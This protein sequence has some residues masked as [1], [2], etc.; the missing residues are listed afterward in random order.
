MMSELFDEILAECNGINGEER[1]E[2][3]CL[4]AKFYDCEEANCPIVRQFHGRRPADLLVE[5]F[6]LKK[7]YEEEMA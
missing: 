4:W 3:K 5:R 2:T 1:D 7:Q 6:N